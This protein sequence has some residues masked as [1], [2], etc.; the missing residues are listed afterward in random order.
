[1]EDQLSVRITWDVLVSSLH[2]GRRGL[3]WLT[4]GPL[5]ILPFTEATNA[6]AIVGANMVRGLDAQNG[7]AVGEPEAR[8]CFGVEAHRLLCRRKNTGKKT[9]G[10]AGTH[11][12][13]ADAQRHTDRTDEPLSE[14][15]SESLPASYGPGAGM[16]VRAML[17]P[18]VPLGGS[19]LVSTGAA[20]P[21][22]PLRASRSATAPE[23]G[24]WC[25]TLACVAPVS[26]G[27]GDG[28]V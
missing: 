3:S 2:F 6:R 8:S 13:H 25:E 11:T 27:E 26:P 20:S 7:I 12:G 15:Y 1:M 14:S 5:R 18:F 24:L 4:V 28:M 10:G 19:V 21:S 23:Q 22:V 17:A 16:L 9:P